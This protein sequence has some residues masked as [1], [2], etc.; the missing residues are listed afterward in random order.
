MAHF[1]RFDIAEAHHMFASLYHGGGGDPIYA[2]FS[3]LVRIGFKPAPTLDVETLE[4]NG[5]EIFDNLVSKHGFDPYVNE[6]NDTPLRPT[7]E[8][9]SYDDYHKYIYNLWNR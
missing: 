8:F 9:A 7:S 5:R 4:E 6:D 2:K 1:D 3:T